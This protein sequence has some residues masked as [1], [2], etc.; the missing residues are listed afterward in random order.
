MI[1]WQRIIANKALQDQIDAK[2]CDED[3]AG[4]GCSSGSGNNVHHEKASGIE[5]NG[6]QPV[7]LRDH[8]ILETRHAIKNLN[9]KN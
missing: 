5:N 7:H 3:K 4:V 1:R 9:N 8:Q 2:N 6:V